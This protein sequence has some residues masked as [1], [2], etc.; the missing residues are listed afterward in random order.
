VNILLISQHHSRS[1]QAVSLATAFLAAALT[2]DELLAASCRVILRDLFPDSPLEESL[3]ELLATS[4][5]VVGISV[6]LWN[7]GRALELARALKQRRPD[8]LLFAGGPEPTVES[9]PFL[10]E[11][12]FDFAVVG[13]G[14]I[15][16]VEAVAALREGRSVTG[17]PGV[18]TLEG[19]DVVLLKRHPTTMLDLLPSPIIT[20][21]LKL[22]SGTGT[23]WQLTRGCDF[24]CSYCCDPAGTKGARRFSL[25]RVEAELRLLAKSDISQI[26]VL[27][28]T[29]NREPDRAK[30]ILRLIRKH[31]PHIHFHFEVRNEFID[32]EQA[33]LFAAITCSLQI[34]L[35]SAD[36]KVLAGVGRRLDRSD[37]SQRIGF[38]NET[39]V[40]FGFD[41]I[42]GLPGDSYEGFRKSLE[43]ALSLYPNHLDIFPLA[44]LPGAPLAR[45][46]RSLGL[47]HLAEPPYTLLESPT[48]PRTEMAR[49]ARLAEACDIFYSRGKAVAWFNGVCRGLS[50]TP[51]VVLERFSGWLD[52]QSPSVKEAELGDDEVWRFQRQFLEF[53][54]GEQGKKRLLPLALDL[55]DYH[56]HYAAALL[57]VPP[58][59][60]SERELARLDLA[61]GCF[62]LASST[63]AARFSYEI[64]DIL[65]TGEV[66]LSQ[67]VRCFK[68]SGSCAVIYPRG[69]EVLTESLAEPFYRLLERLDGRKTVDDIL[70]SMGQD[71]EE[72]LSFLEFAVAEGIVV[73]GVKRPGKPVC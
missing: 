35:Q 5:H 37:F 10:R 8:L 51:V 15:T 64:V 71:R 27:D 28:S 21:A 69:G 52:G 57:A 50:L 73:A 11:G 32:Q 13:E 25:A 47:D 55:V 2:G 58:E 44:I 72:A 62:I 45:S 22:S 7:R 9:L 48:F 41:L 43:F 66:E 54:F 56:H 49:A 14:E 63:V 46:A 70:K 38:L 1:P 23:L 53:L 29:F 4:P 3:D 40:I 68:K 67:F 12:L 31:A 61:S 59:V 18:A 17:I 6:Y 19:E 26:F 30:R 16:F 60:P 65:E 33:R 34:G 24:G 42:Y 20:G 39:G 36:P